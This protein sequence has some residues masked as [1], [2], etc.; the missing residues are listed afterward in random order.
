VSVCRLVLYVVL[1][2]RSVVAFRRR[3]DR[4]KGEKA[5]AMPP[6]KGRPRT[7]VTLLGLSVSVIVFSVA[8]IKFLIRDNGIIGV[9]DIFT[10][11]QLVPLLVGVFRLAN[12]VASLFV[13]RR[14]FKPRY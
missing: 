9:D 8:S 11:G 14:V 2:R 3:R 7:E 10:A 4:G 1:I 12:S 6:D 13:D 5:A